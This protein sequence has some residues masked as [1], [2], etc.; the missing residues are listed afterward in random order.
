MIAPASPPEVTSVD[1]SGL[2]DE[3]YAAINN[4]AVRR[5]VSFD[6]AAS[7]LLLKHARKLRQQQLSRSSKA[8]HE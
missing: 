6:E 4:E 1:L 2:S 5:G 7:S 3:E 8:S